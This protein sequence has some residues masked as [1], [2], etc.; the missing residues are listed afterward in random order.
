MQ[1]LDQEEMVIYTFK[2]ATTS[3]SFPALC[4][5]FYRLENQWPC[6]GRIGRPPHFPVVRNLRYRLT[7]KSHGAPMAS[8]TA[9]KMTPNIKPSLQKSLRAMKPHP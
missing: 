2:D 5:I 8:N 3:N 6:G 4:D 7:I 1:H 9:R